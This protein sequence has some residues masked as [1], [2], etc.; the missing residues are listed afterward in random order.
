M[1]VFDELRDSPEGRALRDLVRAIAV[2]VTGKSSVSLRSGLGKVSPLGKFDDAHKDED[3]FLIGN[4]PSLNQTDLSQLRGKHVFG[5]NKIYL[6]FEKCPID[7]SYLVAVN[8]YVIEQ[9]VSTYREM[10]VPVF[11]PKTRAISAGLTGKNHFGIRIE[12]GFSFGEHMTSTF[13]EGATVTFTA[14]QLAFAMGF[15]RVFLIGVDHSFKQEGKPNEAQKMTGDDPN[16][17]HPDYF[18]GVQWQLA[19]IEGSEI[20]YQIARYVYHREGRQIIDA[21]VG[22]KLDLFPKVDYSEAVAMCE[23]RKRD[24]VRP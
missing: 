23:A 10:D 13:A 22:G 21:T 5:L 16:H 8:P 2:R 20:A 24:P 7:L 6:M 12:G 18:K 19:D 9:S 3:C 4:G 17:F 14:M 1:S 15:K 11:M